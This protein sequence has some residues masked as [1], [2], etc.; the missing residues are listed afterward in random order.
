MVG[1]RLCVGGRSGVGDGIEHCNQLRDTECVCE[2]SEYSGR[3][4]QHEFPFDRPC[5]QRGECGGRGD[6]RDSVVPGERQPVQQTVARAGRDS[7]DV[8]VVDDSRAGRV[9]HI[10][11]LLHGGQRQHHQDGQLSRQRELPSSGLPRWLW[12]RDDSV[13]VSKHC[14]G[15]RDIAVA[16]SGE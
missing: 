6:V 11:Q 14:S 8:V 3:V 1:G 2:S 5:A 10:W 7:A 13:C 9:L 15:G 4:G 12:W 16:D